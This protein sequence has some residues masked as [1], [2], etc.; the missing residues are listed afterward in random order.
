MQYVDDYRV[1]LEGEDITNFVSETT[2]DDA[3]DALAVE[4]SFGVFISPW[5]KYVKKL[6]ISPGDN[7]KITNHDNE[8]FQGKVVIVS[9]DG[10][11]TAY[12]QGRYLNS[13]E[14]ILQCSS[15]QADDAIRQLCA[16]AGVKAGTIPEMS[17]MIE[18]LWVGHTAATIL[19]EIL[20]TCTA[21]TGKQYHYRVSGGKLCVAELT[22]EP[23]TA[24]HKPAGNI[25]PFDITWA[26]GKVSG[27]DSAEGLYNAVVIAAEKDGNVSVGATASN[28]TSKLRHGALQYVETVNLDPGEAELGSMAL[29]LLEQ[30]DRVSHTRH[31]DEIWGAD[32]VKSGVVLSFNSPQFGIKGLYRVIHVVHHYGRAGHTME[33]ELQALEEPR[34]SQDAAW[35]KGEKELPPVDD[36]LQVYGLPDSFGGDAELGSDQNDGNGKAVKPGD[37]KSFVAVARGEIG[38]PETRVKGADG[39][40]RSNWNKYGEWAGNNGVAWDT[41]FVCWCADQAGAPIPTNY[42]SA[43]VMA[44]Y[45]KSRN[46][47]KKVSSG[48]TPKPGD[49]AVC[50]KRLAIVESATR[51]SIQTIEGNHS[52]RVER[53]TR[54]YSEISGFCTPWDNLTGR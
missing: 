52:N 48:Y 45:F 4:A 16:K 35:M 8:L 15:I 9:L 29:Q 20:E 44:N 11:V 34:A 10:Q 39:K 53:V 26:L 21:K 47:Y 50:G 27:E 32:E 18:G 46:L 6:S 41:Q 36:K 22:R 5:D 14:I 28:E 1:I 2:L 54:Y 12:D 23:I 37:A 40:T 42:A 17:T 31:I 33:L 24:Y 19:N 30:Y 38:Q 3:I 43:N 13:S 7:V 25:A 49:L 51:A